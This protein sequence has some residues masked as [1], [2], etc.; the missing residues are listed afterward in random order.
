MENALSPSQ[1][2]DIS[3]AYDEQLLLHPREK[4]ALRTEVPRIIERDQRFEQ[5]MDLPPV[6]RILHAELGDDIEL[7]SGG[8]LDHKYEHTPAYIGWHND[9]VWMTNVPYPRQNYWLRTTYFIGD[10]TE[11]GGPFTLLPGSHR[12]DHA[13]P[14]FKR[15]DG[16]PQP[17]RPMSRTTRGASSCSVTN[18]RG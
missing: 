7:S 18:T 12:K 15:P 4:G 9:F 6:F 5:L 17:I 14:E 2:E 11:K 3:A 8:E 13:C 16:Q 1:L 10:V